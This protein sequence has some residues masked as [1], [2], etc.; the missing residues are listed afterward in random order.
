[1][2]NIVSFL[3]T[4]FFYFYDLCI[5]ESFDCYVIVFCKFFLKAY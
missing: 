4:E 2:S 1:M 3:L 5:H